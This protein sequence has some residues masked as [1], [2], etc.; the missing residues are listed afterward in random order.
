[1]FMQGYSKKQ[2]SP[3]QPV[4][5]SKRKLQ[6]K[7]VYLACCLA[8]LIVILLLVILLSGKNNQ[9]NTQQMENQQAVLAEVKAYENVFAPNIY[10]D[11]VNVGGLTPDE[12]IRAVETN[13]MN[14][15]SSWSVNVTYEGHTF[16]TITYDTLG[17]DTEWQRR[18]AH[19]LLSQAYQLGH[20]DDPLQSKQEIDYL[21]ENPY[22]LYTTQSA[23]DTAQL[24]QILGQIGEYFNRQ[25]VDAKLV[26]FYPANWDD[27]FGIQ[28][29]SYGSRLET[30]TVRQQILEMAGRGESGNI[31]LQP[32]FIPPAITEQ[33]VRKSVTLIGESITPID[34]SS[35]TARTDNIRVAF[36]RYHGMEVLPGQTVS[37]NKV[38][39]PRTMENG[40]QMA[41]EYANGLSVPGW[42]GGVCQAS[43]TIYKAVLTAN[44]EVTKRTS[45]SDKVTYTEF[46]QDATVYYSPDRKIDFAFRNNTNSKIYIMARVESVG[47]NKYQCVVRIYGNS[48]GENVTYKLHTRTVETILAPL[49][50]EYQEDKNHEYV[51]YKDEEPYLVRKA[52][53]GFI[54]ETYLQRWENGVMVSEE[55]IS[56]DECKA[57][58]ALYLTGTKNRN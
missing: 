40:F 38:V 54:N 8:A 27:P 52:R 12:A 21:K 46:G 37:F 11:G 45:H 26:Y 5:G 49:M 29:E 19:D 50:P 41:I 25:P 39:G 33:D 32:Q 57:R 36:N 28:P 10:V 4:K 20:R 15:N 1:M 18:Q 17:I 23:L 51:T 31:E 7:A 55:L 42:G 13:I 35:T 34:K 44:L 24:D 9:K 53:D 48:L 3:K 2:N 6:P 14:R 16:V 47:K 30:A 58:T 43:T 22:Y 56:R